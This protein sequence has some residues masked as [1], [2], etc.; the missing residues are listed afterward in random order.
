MEAVTIEEFWRNYAQCQASGRGPQGPP[1]VDQ[2]G[3]P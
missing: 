2:S 1:I 3:E